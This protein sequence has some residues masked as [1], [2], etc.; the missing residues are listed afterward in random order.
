MKLI[1]DDKIPFLHGVPE[2]LGFTALYIEGASISPRDVRDADALIVRT[3]TR[4]DA[5]LLDGSRVRMVS[6]A[7]IGYDHLD[8]AWLEGHG[9][10]WTNAPGCNAPSVGQYVGSALLA[11]G[12]ERH[13]DPASWTVGI[14]GVGHVG[15]E[16]DKAL[17]SLGCR[18]LLCDAPRRAMGEKGFITLEDIARKS[19]VVTFHVPL[20]REGPF[21]TRHMAGD[22]FFSQLKRGAVVINAARGGVVDEGALLLAMEQGVV[23]AAIIDTWEGE[24]HVCIPLLERCFLAT[25]HIAGYS[26]DGKAT[27]SRMALEA[28]CRFF[29]VEP[30]FTIT[31]P[32]LPSGL[33]TA[34]DPRERALQLYDPRGDSARLKAD[35]SRFE[36][37][38]GHYPLRRER[39]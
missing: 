30:A 5:S 25:P 14:V 36:W 19:D 28:V 38:R 35:P 1:I 8:T 24:P 15:Q 22:A 33:V 37:L 12:K 16:V 11:L 9:I 27:A 29:H 4:C 26:A 6:T 32:P 21:A 39:A 18:T 31:P 13:T 17:R 20:T 34:T 7:T 3:R 10:V 23:S 2:R